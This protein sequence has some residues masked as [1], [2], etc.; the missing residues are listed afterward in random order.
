MGPL[1]R[2]T[3][4]FTP[5]QMV[6]SEITNFTT[7]LKLCQIHAASEY[8]ETFVC[9]LVK[10]KQKPT[11][12]FFFPLI[13]LSISAAMHYIPPLTSS[14]IPVNPSRQHMR[15]EFRTKHCQSV[16]GKFI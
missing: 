13:S 10:T 9:L 3:A 12:T 1:E 6:T 7:I 15:E 11:Q 8:V 14:V 5:E 4:Q 2:A 16:S